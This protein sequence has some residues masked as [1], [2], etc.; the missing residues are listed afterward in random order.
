MIDRRKIASVLLVLGALLT[1]FASFQNTYGTVYQYGRGLDQSFTTTLWIVKGAPQTSSVDDAY[2]AAGGPVMITA[3]LALVAVVLMLRERSAFIGRPLAMGAAGALAGVVFFY[4]AQIQHE[5]EMM[6]YW[7]TGDG[8]SY[9]LNY[10]AGTYLLG[11]GAIIAV[12]GAAL[13]QQRPQ[14]VVQQIDDE[15]AVV[16]H[17]LDHDDDTPPFGTEIPPDAQQETR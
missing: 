9:E 5:K 1:A 4:V 16:V 8:Q 2:Y 13:A 10:F 3:V 17:Q 12:I 11:A 14:P 7:P 15:D 6:S